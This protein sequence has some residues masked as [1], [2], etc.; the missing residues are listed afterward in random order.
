MS[1]TDND[2]REFI[3]SLA[4][5]LAA[6]EAFGERGSM[7]LSEVARAVSISPGSARRVL[8][9]L[10]RLGYLSRQQSRFSLLPRTLRLGYAYLLSTPLLTIVQPMLTQLTRELDES[11]SLSALDGSDIVIIARATARRLTQDYV[12][13]GSRLPAHATSFGKVLLSQLTDRQIDEVLPGETL[14]KLT[15]RTIS[16]RTKLKYH[17][18]GVRENGWA[19]NDEESILGLR[20]IAVAVES[21]TGV[22]AALGLST[23]IARRSPEAMVGHYLPSLQSTARQLTALLKSR[24]IKS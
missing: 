4:K 11:C 16:E 20:S 3:Q 13:V 21:D 7:T 22:I 12:L 2:E 1:T 24:A 15:P 23:E 6:M 5:G 10:E 18:A 14:Q 8:T 19:I 9:T 17:L